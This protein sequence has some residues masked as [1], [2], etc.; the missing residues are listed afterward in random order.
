MPKRKSSTS[1][2]HPGWTPFEEFLSDTDPQ[3]HQKIAER[4]AGTSPYQR[5]ML[6]PTPEW[7]KENTWAL[8]SSINNDTL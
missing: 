8:P 5:P 7:L 6:G 1:S 3:F 4:I 2:P